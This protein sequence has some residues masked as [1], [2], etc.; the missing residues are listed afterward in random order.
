MSTIE[1]NNSNN[2]KYKI[3][4]MKPNDKIDVLHCVKSVRIQSY[5]GPHFPAFGLITEGYGAYGPD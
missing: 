4:K 2:N 1:W 3:L 5:S